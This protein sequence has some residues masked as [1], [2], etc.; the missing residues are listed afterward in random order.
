MELACSFGDLRYGNAI[1]SAMFAGKYVFR[2]DPA[3]LLG[4]R[5]ASASKS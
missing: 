5:R 4:L 2:F 1:D 3:P